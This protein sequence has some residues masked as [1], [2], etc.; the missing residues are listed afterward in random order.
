[1]PKRKLP[2]S[3]QQGTVYL[4]HLSVPVGHASHYIGFAL[5]HEARFREHLAGRGGRLLAVANSRGVRYEVVRI[6][7]LAD[8]RFERRA[9][10]RSCAP[11]LCPICNPETWKNWLPEVNDARP[12]KRPVRK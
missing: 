8:R 2:R 7:L 5:D 9:K 6:W 11:K 3:G 4:I 12:I 1:M 10:N